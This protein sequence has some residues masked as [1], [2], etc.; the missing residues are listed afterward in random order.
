MTRV[1]VPHPVSEGQDAP[2][3]PACWTRWRCAGLLFRRR[4]ATDAVTVVDVLW[5]GLWWPCNE[6][7]ITRQEGENA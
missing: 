7:I 2:I 3:V 4:H 6:E 1:Y 5:D